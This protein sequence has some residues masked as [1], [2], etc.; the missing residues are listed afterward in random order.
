[1]TAQVAADLRAAAD[2]LEKDGWTQGALHSAADCGGPHCAR[3]AIH[4]ATGVVALYSSD[5]DELVNDAY[6]RAEHAERAFK[7]A[8]GIG[9]LIDWNDSRESADEVIA[10]LRAAADAAEASDD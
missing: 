2:V 10:A 3:G 4:V 1:M 5:D 9:S 6:F 7:S 8:L